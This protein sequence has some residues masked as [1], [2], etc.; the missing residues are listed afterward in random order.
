MS[1]HGQLKR[2]SPITHLPPSC[3]M[4]KKEV[5]LIFN[6]RWMTLEGKKIILGVT[7]SIAAYKSASLV[8]LLVQDGAEVQVVMTHTA[9][10]F[11]TPLTLSTLSKR[12][13]ITQYTHANGTWENHVEW[14][15]WADLIVIAPATAHF[16]GTC[17]QGLCP[18]VLSAIYLSA[19]CPVMWAPAM[20]L[21]M[22]IHPATQENRARL[23]SFGNQILEA[24]S[25]ELASGLVG[26]GRLMEPERIVHHIQSFFNADPLWKNKRVLITAGPTQE[27]IDPVRYI[28]NHSTGKMG[29]A[30]AKACQQK[31]AKVT[32]ISGPV[33]IPF[34]EG[35]QVIPVVSAQ[36]MMQ[37]AV[38]N[39]AQQDLVIFS[40]AVADYAP[41]EVSSRKVKKSATDWSISLKQN[42]DVAGTLAFQKKPGQI[43]VGFA[44]ETHQERDYA[45][46]KW[47]KKKFDFLVLNSLQ[48]AG[49]GFRYDTNRVSLLNPAGNWIEFPLQSKQTLAFDLL[50]Q[51]STVW[52]T[53]NNS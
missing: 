28:S 12:P 19:K 2:S 9:H 32:L 52:T 8:R 51:F 17:A 46:K 14:G 44:L 35:V 27:A 30:L 5:S 50:D 22:Y 53:S 41:S 6:D 10:E 42:P 36:E 21:D 34:P 45:R 48:D 16:M 24:E 23:K 40:A 31:G 11:I 29:F 39:N 38:D 47:E 3:S 20:D 13:V 4:E 49:A 1:C 25:G 43:H 33:S 15:M 7:G 37:A 18:D 26:Q